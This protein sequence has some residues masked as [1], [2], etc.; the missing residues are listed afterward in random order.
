M[1]GIKVNV[2]WLLFTLACFLT[3]EGRGLNEVME[4]GRR[5]TGEVN[6]SEVEE[7][8]K[9]FTDLDMAKTLTKRKMKRSV[10]DEE[11]E[12]GDYADYND[13]EQDYPESNTLYEDAPEEEETVATPKFVS[14]PKVVIVNEG[15]TIRLPCFVDD[16]DSTKTM[17]WIWKL[18]DQI[19]ALNERPY[20]IAASRVKIETGNG[21][22][23]QLVIMMATKEDAGQYICQVSAAE[24]IFLEH[25][26]K[27]RVRPEVQAKE[28]LVRVVSGS[29]ATLAC[30][31]TQGSP[32][33]K[34]SW[35]RKGDQCQ[36]ELHLLKATQSLSPRHRDTFLG[37]I[38][39]VLTMDG[40]GQPQQR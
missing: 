26:V 39:A 21:A 27:I 20:D 3:T 29:E 12:Y 14:Q 22:G 25:T 2:V 32:M 10:I 1:V 7:R 30:Q 5:N 34:V 28:K 33:P 13:G 36:Q 16:S 19:L 37:S 31:V 6:L 40:A 38:F 18:G 9:T 11:E 8:P 15:D 17:I 24:N 4:T 35:R 23:N